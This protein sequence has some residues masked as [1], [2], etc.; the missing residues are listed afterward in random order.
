MGRSLRIGSGEQGLE[1]RV[2]AFKLVFET[3][4]SIRPLGFRP[5]DSTF[6]MCAG[7]VNASI[8]TRI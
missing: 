8:S 4:R 7:V 6:T 1:V 2:V 5:S 3:K